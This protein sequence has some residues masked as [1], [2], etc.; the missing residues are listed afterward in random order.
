MTDAFSFAVGLTEDSLVVRIDGHGTREHSPAFVT[1]VSAI[2]TQ[3]SGQRLIVD[4][5]SCRFLDSKF[6]GCLV[7]LYRRARNHMCICATD[8][9]RERLFA[10]TRIDRLIPMLEPGSIK[11]PAEWQR[12]CIDHACSDDDLIRNVAAAHRCLADIDGPNSEIYRNVADQLESELEAQ[13]PD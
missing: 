6:L 11:R 1:A 3:S 8:P 9:Q 7:V 13:H 10:S 4:L 12:G 5:D 2:V